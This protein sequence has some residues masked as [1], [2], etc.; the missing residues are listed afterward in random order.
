ME[1]HAR[2]LFLVEDSRPIEIPPRTP[3]YHLEPIGVGT[4]DVESLSSYISRLAAIYHSNVRDLLL[5]V[6]GPASLSHF[7]TAGRV[8]VRP[9]PRGK[10]AFG[11]ISSAINGINSVTRTLVAILEYLTG[12]HSLRQ[13]TLLP[14]EK[15]IPTRSLLRKT[16]VWCPVC[17]ENQSGQQPIYDLLS[18]S[19]QD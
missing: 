10:D 16:R 13:L 9:L 6:V 3:L 11:T 1:Q 18:W 15:V 19:F 5:E 2:R 12:E 14:F 4:G 7:L 17:Y 8:L